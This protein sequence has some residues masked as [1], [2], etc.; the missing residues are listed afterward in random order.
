MSLTVSSFPVGKPLHCWLDDDGFIIVHL[1]PYQYKFSTRTLRVLQLCADEQSIDMFDDSP[2]TQSPIS[3]SPPFSPEPAGPFR[4][5]S[6]SPDPRTLMIDKCVGP[7]SPL[8]VEWSLRRDDRYGDFYSDEFPRRV[9]EEWREPEGMFDG[10]LAE[11]DF[12]REVMDNSLTNLLTLPIGH[13]QRK[14]AY[15]DALLRGMSGD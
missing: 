13:P 2:Y 15:S 12:R 14:M 6:F 4:T 7:D 11:R 3:S 5:P 10:Y 9:G 1:A 8:P